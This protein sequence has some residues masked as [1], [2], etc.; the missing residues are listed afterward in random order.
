[1][2]VCRCGSTL[3]PGSPS[4]RCIKCGLACCSTCSYVLGSA[5]CCTR[6]AESVLA[7]H[8]ASVAPAAPDPTPR[9]WL[10]AE[11]AASTQPVGTSQWII[12]VAR[13]QPDLFA[14]LALSF[15]GDDKVDVVLDRG[16][17]AAAHHAIEERLRLRGVAVLKRHPR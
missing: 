13:D 8:G 6:C 15:A 10:R 4:L 14:H 1:V 9:S 11:L 7:A 17:L 2:R 12:L 16:N 5:A 3:G